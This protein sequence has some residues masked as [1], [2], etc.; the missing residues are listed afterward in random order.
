MELQGL[1]STGIPLAVRWEAYG[2]IEPLSLRLQSMWAVAWFQHRWVG[3]GSQGL[4]VG[5]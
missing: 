1:M 3:V 5:M 4:A 2:F